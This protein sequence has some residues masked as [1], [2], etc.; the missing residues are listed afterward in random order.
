MSRPAKGFERFLSLWA[1]QEEAESNCGMMSGSGRRRRPLILASTRAV[2]DSV[3]DDDGSD[4]ESEASEAVSTS[5]STSARIR[6]CLQICDTLTVTAGLLRFHHNHN[7]NDDDE[8]SD[9]SSFVCV[10]TSLLRQLETVTASL[11]LVKNPDNNVARIAKIIVFDQ[12]P[13]SHNTQQPL[14]P[15]AMGVF[16]SL[17]YPPIN[18]NHLSHVAFLSPLL[19]FNLGFHTSCLKL[20]LPIQ[21]YLFKYFLTNEHYI[22]EPNTS[23]QKQNLSLNLHITPLPILPKYA[24]HL[25]VSFVKIPECGMLPSLK[26]NSLI[27]ASHYQT[28]LDSAL[29]Q[30]FKVDRFLMKGDVFCVHNVWNCRSE[31]CLVCTDNTAK[32]RLNDLIYFKV[33]SMEPSDEPVLRVNCTQTTLVLGGA[34]PSAIPP[35]NLLCSSSDQVPV[36]G[37]AVKTLSFLIASVIYPS[38]LTS[39]F[40]FG[41]LLHGPS[42]CGKRT[43]VRYVAKHTGLHVVEYSC[44]DMLTSSGKGASAALAAAFK[45]A[46]RFAPCIMLLRHLDAFANLPSNEGSQSGQARATMISSII[47]KY[48]EPLPWDDELHATKSDYA[49]LFLV[50]PEL[51]S[52]HQVIVVASADTTEGL[53]PAIWRCFTHDI[54]MAS[55]TEEQRSTLISQKLTGFTKMTNECD[56]PELMEKAA[57]QTSGF[58]SRDKNAV[59]ADVAENAV[60]QDF[61]SSTESTENEAIGFEKAD[62]C[63]LEK[64]FL[65]ALE[66]SKKRIGSALGAPK[67]TNPEIMKKA[68]AQTSG[69]MPRDIDALFADVAANA[70]HQDFISSTENTEIEAIGLEKEFLEV[71]ERSKKRIGSALGA[72]KVPNVKWEDV[73]GLED[74][75]KMILDTIQLPL[76]HKHLFSSGLR[77]RSGMLF[78]GPPGTGKT[79]LAKA[80]A[81][82]CSLHFLSVKGPELIN[83]YIGESEKNVRDIFEKARSA[84]PCVIFFD[85][86]DS[87]APARG[88]AGDS[89]GVMDR[90]VSQMLAEIDG[91]NDSSQDIFIIGAS[92]RPDLIDPALLRP[93]RFDKL[94]YVGVNTDPSYRERVL[95]ALTRKFKLHEDV[96]LF[97]VAKRCPPN[98]TGADMY[99]LCAD[100]WFHAA[101]RQVSDQSMTSPASKD[102]NNLV[103]VEFDDFLKVLSEISPSLSLSELSKYQRLREKFEGPTKRV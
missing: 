13:A 80:V 7:H 88:A 42:G 84:R 17:T 15:S 45:A 55:L 24:S 25:R 74:V 75:K 89:G 8:F 70:V 96:S 77:R 91:L 16:P 40:R 69:F 76:M 51:S 54:S 71:L 12:T 63:S 33:T 62:V 103:V 87:L 22:P 94:V 30:F 19:A 43:V 57:A 1:S 81:T 99:A 10:S 83:M 92:N 65:K 95:Q 9:V 46:H 23:P 32:T 26:G 5:T 11:V 60:H 47:K 28:M 79:L 14:H 37:E 38:V 34:A 93:G 4:S 21:G 59:F 41:L 56:N 82:E 67:C 90:V 97:E 64:E 73:G 86:L 29:N 49:D 39:K 35:Y 36:Q 100:A 3:L 72:P 31:L 53:Q 52:R 66:R 20:L 85:E 68:T 61:I 48:T 44:H 6:R 58:M 50:Q 2:L 18:P 102:N 78:Y 101:K 98:F 27:Q